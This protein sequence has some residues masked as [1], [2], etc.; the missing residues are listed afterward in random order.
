[1]AMP[2]A[3]CRPCI[4]PSPGLCC[5]DGRT[6]WRAHC[7][8]FYPFSMGTCTKLP[9]LCCPA[10]ETVA[11]P[12]LGPGTGPHVVK[13]SCSRCGKF[14]KWL[15]RALVPLEKEVRPM[16]CINMCLVSGYLERDPA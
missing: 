6:H 16:D 10:C 3:E 9:P 14:L 4:C 12:R 1:M 13:A 7:Q 11:L 5:I 15:P 2:I 8:F